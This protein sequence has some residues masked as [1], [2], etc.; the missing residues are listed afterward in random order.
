[1]TLAEWAK[2]WPYLVNW[3]PRIPLAPDY[4]MW[5]PDTGRAGYDYRA[6]AWA[7]SDYRVTSVSGGSIW[8]R[9]REETSND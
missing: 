2:G 3:H 6:L 1:M 9:K 8:F 4:W 5:T 7:L